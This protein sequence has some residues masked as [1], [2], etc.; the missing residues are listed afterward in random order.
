[1]GIGA[2]AKGTCNQRSG[3]KTNAG[4]SSFQIVNISFTFHN[5]QGLGYLVL[6]DKICYMH[7]TSIHDCNFNSG[8]NVLF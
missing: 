8:H 2:C 4:P 1:M 7:M 5:V 6:S 3:S